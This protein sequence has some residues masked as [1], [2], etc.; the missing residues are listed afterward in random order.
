V[1]EARGVLVAGHPSS[2]VDRALDE[3]RHVGKGHRLEVQALHA[4]RGKDRGDVRKV[5]V[6]LAAEALKDSN[7][8][9]GE[10]QGFA[11]GEDLGERREALDAPPAA[12]RPRVLEQQGPDLAELERPKAISVHVAML[13]LCSTQ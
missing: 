10:A 12:D 5:V 6:R 13:G 8:L 2:D 4:R 7:R 1:G 11:D 3:R 9:G